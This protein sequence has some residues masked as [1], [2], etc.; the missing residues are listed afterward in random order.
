ME[1][2]IQFEIYGVML[3][4]YDDERIDKMSCRKWKT[5]KQSNE[6]GYKSICIG[7]DKKVKV[8]RLVYKAHN[9]DWDIEDTS[10]NNYIDHK[11]RCRSNNKI[12]NLQVATQQQNCFNTTAKGYSFHKQ[13]KKYQAQITLDGKSIHLGH[14]DTADEAHNAYLEAKKIYHI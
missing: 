10:K 3:R 4:Y 7:N 12:S 5:L 11:D 6:N 1:A 14:F 8:H 2:F 9:L 13:K